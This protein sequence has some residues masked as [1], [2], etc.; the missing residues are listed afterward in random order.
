MNTSRV[1]NFDISNNDY[2]TIA[3]THN[4]IKD[5]LNLYEED[6]YKKKQKKI[7]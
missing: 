5:N 4:N 2:N 6:N 1:N 3:N 7:I